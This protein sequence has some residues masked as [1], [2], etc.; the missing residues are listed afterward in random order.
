VIRKEGLGEGQSA[1]P[2]KV[3]PP[4]SLREKTH[5]K[6]PGE[7][8]SREHAGKHVCKGGNNNLL[9]GKIQEKF[10]PSTSSIREGNLKKRFL[11]ANCEEIKISRNLRWGT[12]LLTG[13]PQRRK[14]CFTRDY[15]AANGSPLRIMKKKA[16]SSR[17]DR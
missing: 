16:V 1:T 4:E 9:R 8:P 12:F 7:K 2:R 6:D 5:R 15:R 17:L 3:F 10:E 13:E 14:I 11:R